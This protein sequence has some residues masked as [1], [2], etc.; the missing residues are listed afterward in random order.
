M[1][2][3]YIKREGGE[4]GRERERSSNLLATQHHQKHFRKYNRQDSDVNSITR[5][6]HILHPPIKGNIIMARKH[7]IMTALEDGNNIFP[8]FSIKE[9][10]QQFLTPHNPNIK[11]YTFLCMEAKL[12][13]RDIF[14]SKRKIFEKQEEINR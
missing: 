7:E 8:I 1:P 2:P 11:N 12:M 3:I 4:G 9:S 5:K 13:T 10:S 14:Y 6:Q